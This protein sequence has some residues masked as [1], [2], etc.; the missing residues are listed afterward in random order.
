MIKKLFKWCA[1][2][3]SLILLLCVSLLAYLCFSVSGRS[4]LINTTEYFIGKTIGIEVD[5]GRIT[6]RLNQ[7]NLQHI[8]LSD[9]K[10]LWLSADDIT[11][12]WQP[13]K[14]LNTLETLT[15]TALKIDRVPHT[16]T[17]EAHRTPQD[18]LQNLTIPNVILSH[19]EVKTIQ[20]PSDWIAPTNVLSF[21]GEF[22][23]EK[24][25]IANIQTQAKPLS[26]LQI[27]AQPHHDKIH[28]RLHWQ[29]LAGG[30]LSE[31]IG[32]SLIQQQ[33]ALQGTVLID[34]ITPQVTVK[35]MIMQLDNSTLSAEGTTN[36]NE[37]TA[38]AKLENLST[39]ILN[40]FN[41]PIDNGIIQGNLQTQGTLQNPTASL[42]LT[43]EA[44]A[45]M[46]DSTLR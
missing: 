2:T 1:L 18:I 44:D 41:L 29:E 42:N 14:T 39:D 24:S 31:K 27:E 19:I 20:L 25:L 45:R 5:I 23:R 16:A 10:G 35:N 12:H 3:L 46:S 38:I 7:F 40:P 8:H 37:F 13:L 22:N 4:I 21:T 9:A 43:L 26:K 15:I 34:T 6:G 28:L 17:S 11:V 32:T 33:A 36:F 30:L